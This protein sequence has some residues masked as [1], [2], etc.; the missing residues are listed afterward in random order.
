M[1]TTEPNAHL[2]A[3]GPSVLDLHG[4]QTGSAKFLCCLYTGQQETQI[5]AFLPLQIPKGTVKAVLWE[6]LTD[7]PMTVYSFA[8]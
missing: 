4:G 7:K 5:A 3:P 8:R 6:A 1:G 2:D